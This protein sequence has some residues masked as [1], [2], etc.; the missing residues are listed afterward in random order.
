MRIHEEV[1]KMYV[2]VPGIWVSAEIIGEQFEFAIN[3]HKPCS[4][5]FYR[6]MIGQ[7]ADVHTNFRLEMLDA[8]DPEQCKQWHDKVYTAL[9]TTPS[10]NYLDILNS[11]LTEDPFCELLSVIGKHQPMLTF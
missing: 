5:V 1:L 10:M 2:T 11:V 4:P 3:E 6:A 8:Y 7:P 9:T